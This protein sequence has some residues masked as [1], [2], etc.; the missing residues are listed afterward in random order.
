MRTLDPGTMGADAGWGFRLLMLVV[1]IGG[2][3]IVASLIGIV[4][5]SD[6]KMAQLRKGRSR[7]IESDHT[8]ILG[9]SPQLFLL[10][11][12]VCRANAGRRRAIV[13]LA[14]HDKVEMEDAIR[15]K[16]AAPAAPGSSAAPATRPHRPTWRSP[17]R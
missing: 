9:W 8:L 1:T 4:C 12:E 14:D 2:L 17:T 10:I 16:V 11:G 5:A 7:V 15:E 6:D 3:I 13:V